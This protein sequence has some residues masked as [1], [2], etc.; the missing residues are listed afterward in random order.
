MTRLV[1]SERHVN[2]TEGYRYDC[3]SPY[4]T[5]Y[6]SNERGA[7]YRALQKEYGRCINKQYTE[8]ADGTS[9][10]SGYIFQSKQ[11][12]YDTNKY[13]IRE[14]WVT[15]TESPDYLI[16]DCGVEHSQ[17]FTGLSVAF[18]DYDK[19]YMGAGSSAYEALEDA[20]EQAT[21]EGWTDLPQ[22]TLSKESFRDQVTCPGDEE[23]LGCLACN[24]DMYHYVG[25]YLRED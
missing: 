8:W 10:V 1:V 15:I 6:L 14:V 16:E 13:Y 3:T 2:A 21:T 24:E 4:L 17:Y 25:L 20:L 5:K 12:Y 23:C 22:N 19:I 7:L 18:T 9:T 11:R